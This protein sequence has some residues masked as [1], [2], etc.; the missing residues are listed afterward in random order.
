MKKKTKGIALA[1][2]M[3]LLCPNTLFAQNNDNSRSY[4]GIQGGIPMAMSTTSSFGGDKTRCGWSAVIFVGN[5]FTDVFGIEFQLNMGKACMSP[6]ECCYVGYNWL[7]EDGNH[8]ISSILDMPSY[9]YNALMSKV[10]LFDYGLHFNFNMLPLFMSSPS[11]WSVMLSPGVTTQSS[12]ATIYVIE[13]N[14]KFIS[15]PAAWNVGLSCRLHVA[16]AITP[17]ISLGLYTG[18]T[19]V[20]GDGIDGFPRFYHSANTIWDSG[21]RLTY[22][23]KKGGR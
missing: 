20:S 4:V 23:L 15:R 6:R 16:Y 11:R 13:D 22:S 2:M 19:Y 18:L 3:L 12:K 14:S 7:G 1:L 17:D 10:A 8:Y 21:L 9:H 5:Q